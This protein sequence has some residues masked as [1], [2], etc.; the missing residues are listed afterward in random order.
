MKSQGEQIPAAVGRTL[1][2]LDHR[3]EVSGRLR[4]PSLR[5]IGWCYFM[6]GSWG[7]EVTNLCG[8]HS[9]FP[10]NIPLDLIFSLLEPSAAVFCTQKLGLGWTH[11]EPSVPGW[12][13]KGGVRGRIWGKR[14]SIEGEQ[15][16]SWTAF[17]DPQCTPTTQTVKIHA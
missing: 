2:Q 13:L 17:L 11:G 9:S 8:G 4:D 1:D 7:T 5:G 10:P 16:W 14:C 3:K 15:I 12:L 6:E